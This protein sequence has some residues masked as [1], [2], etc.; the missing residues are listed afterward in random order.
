MNWWHE[1]RI[2][3]E[4]IPNPFLKKQDLDPSSLK[5]G[6]GSSKKFAG[7]WFWISDP[8]QGDQT[9]YGS[10]TQPPEKKK[11]DPDPTILKVRI[12]IR[13]QFFK[14]NRILIRIRNSGWKFRRIDATN[15]S[16]DKQRI[17]RIYI[18]LLEKL[19]TKRI[20]IY[21]SF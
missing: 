12:Q 7:N 13:I 11:P 19:N 20:Y 15:F 18:I 1:R 16:G 8:D 17:Y 5:V 10:G 3:V 4:N 21:L 6:S 9:K 2:W 14:Y